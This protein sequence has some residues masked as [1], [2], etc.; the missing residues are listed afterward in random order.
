MQLVELTDSFCRFDA[1]DY[2]VGCEDDSFVAS[3]FI[4]H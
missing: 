3:Y 1:C 4:L 2:V